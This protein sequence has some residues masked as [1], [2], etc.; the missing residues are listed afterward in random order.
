M[1]YEDVLKDYRGKMCKCLPIQSIGMWELVVPS[2]TGEHN[3]IVEGVGRDCVIVVRDDGSPTSGLTEVIP[4]SR[5]ATFIP[6]GQKTKE[7]SARFRRRSAKR[8]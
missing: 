2:A 7:P 8:G 4:L 3:G 5:L 1:T 6:H